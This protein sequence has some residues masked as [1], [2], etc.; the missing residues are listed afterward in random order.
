MAG[1][2]GKRGR[3]A[4]ERG[5]A[6]FEHRLGRI[7]DARVDVAERLQREQIGGVFD[8]VEDIGGR[9]VDRRDARAGRRIGLG[10]GMERQGVET[11]IFWTCRPPTDTGEIAAILAKPDADCKKSLPRLRQSAE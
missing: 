6:L 2:D 3:A 10:A 4:F 7:H 9:L 11:R 1:G 8:V 5:D